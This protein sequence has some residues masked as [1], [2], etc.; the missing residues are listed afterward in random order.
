MAELGPG[1]PAFHREI[2]AEAAHDGVQALVAVGELA[3]EYVEGAAGVPVTR[4][5]PDA[6]AAAA[7]VDEVVE[8]GD[9]VLVKASRA[10]GL[11]VVAEALAAVRA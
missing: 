4:W 10:L 7:G 6:T 1:A 2:G 5:Y 9:C 3:R 8:P 11:E